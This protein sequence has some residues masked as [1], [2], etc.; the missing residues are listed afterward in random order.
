LDIDVVNSTLVFTRCERSDVVPS[1]FL[2]V[3]TFAKSF[4]EAVTATPPLSVGVLSS[5]RVIN[6]VTLGSLIGLVRA[7]IDAC[8]YKDGVVDIVEG[9]EQDHKWT[10][11]KECP[12]VE[13]CRA[14]AVVTYDHGGAED[15]RCGCGTMV[16]LKTK[17]V[18]SASRIDWDAY[19]FQMYLGGS[20]TLVMGT[21]DAGT[22]TDMPSHYSLD[23]IRSKTTPG[24]I[25]RDFAKLES[26]LRRIRQIVHE[27]GL[28]QLTLRCDGKGGPLVIHARDD[29]PRVLPM[30]GHIFGSIAI[31]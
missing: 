15:D 7:E 5:Y 8:S 26:L 12:S 29:E 2:P 4:E 24:C 9:H 6:Q 11:V 18:K 23:E 14:G 10:P 30:Q 31:S 1:Q 28:Q 20:Q 3:N 19:Y 13:V 25:E 22:F 16:E 21:H 27:H 17:S